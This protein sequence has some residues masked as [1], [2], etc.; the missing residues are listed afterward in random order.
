MSPPRRKLPG[1]QP[2]QPPPMSSPPSDTARASRTSKSPRR[3]SAAADSAQPSRLLASLLHA[4]ER[5]PTARKLLLA[6][7]INFARELLLALA[8]R[9]GGWIGW[10]A[11]NLRGIAELLAFAPLSR[12]SLRAGGDIE[13]GA[14][15]NAALDA[16]IA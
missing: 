10:E 4:T 13:I 1:L 2:T 3:D 12:A 14:L 8:R 15:V 16:T 11:A 6:P 5:H 7:D 9:S